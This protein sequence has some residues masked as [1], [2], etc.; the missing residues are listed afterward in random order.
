MNGRQ[1]E[2]APRAA[3]IYGRLLAVYPARHRRQYGPQMVQLFRDQCWDAL[4]REGWVGLVGLWCRV[5]WDTARTSVVEHITAIQRIDFMKITSRL[6][7][8]NWLAAVAVGMVAFLLVVTASVVVTALLPRSYCS[9]ARVA[10]EKPTEG[11]DAT[12]VAAYDPY[13]LQTEV[14]ILASRAVLGNVI[15][16][17]DLNRRWAARYRAELVTS[18]ETYQ[19]LRRM[20]AVRHF[21]NTSLLEVRVF[22]ED[23]DEAAAIANQIVEAYHRIASSSPR[24][25]LV[26]ITDAAEPGL[27]PV[28]PNV[29]LNVMVGLMAG[30]L[31]GL[32]AG[33]VVILIQWLGKGGI[34]DHRK[35]THFRPWMIVINLILGALLTTPEVLTQLL[36][37]VP[38]QLLYELAVWIAWYWERQK[39]RGDVAPTVANAS[40]S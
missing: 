39:K 29:P 15:E 27:R 18:E 30:L 26:E 7:S 4:E 5:L 8:S 25:R 32:L 31:A 19:L 38:L 1:N 17:L 20:V 10:V 22:S 34:L 14:E 36:M 9:V 33:G 40:S 28:R 6:T 11:A 37:F 35:L 16:G 2:V 24:R 12:R 3:R 13:F 23:R 21:R